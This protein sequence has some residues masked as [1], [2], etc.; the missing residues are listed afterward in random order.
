MERSENFKSRTL[1][2][3]LNPQPVGTVTDRDIPGVRSRLGGRRVGRALCLIQIMEVLRA[4]ALMDHGA[5]R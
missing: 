1:V 2:W 4:P 5:M 3:R